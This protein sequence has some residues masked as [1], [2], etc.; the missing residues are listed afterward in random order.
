MSR[1]LTRYDENGLLVQA[2]SLVGRE[3]PTV[4]V[5]MSGTLTRHDEN[6]RDGCKEDKGFGRAPYS[7]PSYTY[8]CRFKGETGCQTRCRAA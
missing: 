1:A 3:R 8:P 6:D 7:H 4:G 5:F 2:N